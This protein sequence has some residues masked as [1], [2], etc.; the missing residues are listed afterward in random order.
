MAEI[1]WI[2]LLR[3]H[4]P[5]GDDLAPDD[6]VLKLFDRQRIEIR[7]RVRVIA[8]RHPGI[9]PLPEQR[10][11]GIKLALG[12]KLAFVNDANGWCAVSL[13]HAQQF[14]CDTLRSVHIA[15]TTHRRIG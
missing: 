3:F 1:E 9:Y 13:Q 14:R 2:G 7:M 11:A 5:P 4:E 8:E 15:A 10:R 12:L 6:F